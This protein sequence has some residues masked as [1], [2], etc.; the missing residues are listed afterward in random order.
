MK[1]VIPQS[2]VGD[3]WRL[4]ALVSGHAEAFSRVACESR[5]FLGPWMSFMGDSDFDPPAARRYIED[6]EALWR[7][8]REFHFGIWVGATMIGH[9]TFHLSG[10]LMDSRVAEMSL[11][12]SQEVAGKGMGSKVLR[13]LIAW[14]FWDWPWLRL[15]WHCDANN[16]ASRRLAEKSGF[17]CEGTMQQAMVSHTGAWIDK[18]VYSL[19]KY[20]P[21]AAAQLADL[22]VVPATA[23][24]AVAM[25]RIW[26]DVIH[27][28]LQ[29]IAPLNDIGHLSNR[30][31]ATAWQEF[32]RQHEG[33]ANLICRVVRTK[34]DNRVVGFGVVTVAGDRGRCYGLFVP[35]PYRRQGVG[36]Q[37]WQAMAAA[38][39]EVA[40]RETVLALP[41][42]LTK[43]LTFYE[44]L[45]F[46]A[47]NEPSAQSRKDCEWLEYSLIHSQ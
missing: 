14:G 25:G 39:A 18:L 31:S 3:G 9:T 20:P 7:Q 2:L 1:F 36:R 35:G 23:A 47:T 15:E 17:V 40:V 26:S 12:F 33:S 24:D 4:E 11:W 27:E 38:Q 16:T 46:V 5:A 45:G 13:E 34:D 6:S 21:L 10:R 8:L 29:H 44:S 28:D 41:K 22:S 37:L 42:A 19:A 43:G 32:W 30:N